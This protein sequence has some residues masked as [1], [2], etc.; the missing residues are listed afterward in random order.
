MSSPSGTLPVAF[1]RFVHHRLPPRDG[2]DRRITAKRHYNYAIGVPVK[3]EFAKAGGQQFVSRPASTGTPP[4]ASTTTI[5]LY[6]VGWWPMQRDVSPWRR[7]E[8]RFG[9]RIV[10]EEENGRRGP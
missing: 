3:S 8:I 10:I 2:N 7:L 6:R 9:G 1:C 5:Q 4:P